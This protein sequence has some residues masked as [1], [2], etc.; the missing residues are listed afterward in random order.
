VDEHI[1]VFKEKHNI[2]RIVGLMMLHYFKW[3]WCFED[4]ANYVDEIH[5]LLHYSHGTGPDWVKHN[6]KVKGYLELR[7]NKDWQVE[8]W[9]AR[10]G[11]Q[12]QGD[13]RDRALRMLD[14][15]QSELVLFPDE[16]ESFPEPE[17]LVK[18]LERLYRSN[19]NQLAFKRC[20]FWDAMDLVRKD[21][22]IGYQ[23]HVK[24]YK[25][26][27]GLSYLPYI[28]WNCVSTYG[29]KKLVARSVVK[30]Y[31]YMEKEERE[32]RFHEV[33]KE[34]QDQFKGLLETPKLK[35]Y[36]NARKAPRT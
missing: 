10:G 23:P 26:Q 8:G 31:A 36:T 6:P 28:G 33:Y 3:P 5:L 9:Y 22:W 2:N 19:K 27:S 11:S 13:F 17:F 15:V 21:K 29:T 30:H 34:K 14:D 7:E 12:F 4:L 25:W 32:L 35:K 20:N 1:R 24:I 16:D 18:D